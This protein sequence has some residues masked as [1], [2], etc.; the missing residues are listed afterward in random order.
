M[1]VY[2][3][4]IKIVGAITLS[5]I[6]TCLFL[7]ATPIIYMFQTMCSGSFIEPYEAFKGHISFS[8]YHKVT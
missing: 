4:K 5:S 1:E 3:V 7:S 8:R 2:C 6:K